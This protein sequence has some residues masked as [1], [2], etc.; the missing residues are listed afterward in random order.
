MWRNISWVDIESPTP[1]ELDAVA[2][3]FSLDP[4]VIHELGTTTVQSSVSLFPKHLFF[5]LHL[6]ALR[7]KHTEGRAQKEV[8][9]VIGK[10]FLLTVRYEPVDAIHRAFKVL[11]SESILSPRHGRL[12]SHGG[13]L[14]YRVLK[15]VYSSIFQEISIIGERLHQVEDKLLQGKE[16]EL[17]IEI[18]H[19]S[20]ELIAL[21]LLIETHSEPLRSLAHSSTAIFGESYEPLAL[22]LVSEQQRLEK[23]MKGYLSILRDLRNANDSLLTTRQNEI[24]KVLTIMAFITFPLALV[25]SVFGMNTEYLPIVGWTGDF[26][27]I[28]GFMFVLTF[29]F[30]V[31]FRI[32]GWF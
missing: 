31:F 6:P 15:N 20:R 4:T 11:E 3:E 12:K 7:R 2:Q 25:S 14:F 1:E 29:F 27:I 22:A 30:F 10:K 18:S 13:H 17:V 24:M 19:I 9:F 32:K 5:V 8:D 26:W 21:Q 23:Q 16:R 28:T